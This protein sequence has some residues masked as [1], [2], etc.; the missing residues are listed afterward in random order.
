MYKDASIC[1]EETGSVEAVASLLIE[2]G[3]GIERS[4]G[5]LIE[6]RG[7]SIEE[8]K[9]MVLKGKRRSSEAHDEEDNV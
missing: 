7:L 9:E 5:Y 1:W 4:Q 2:R 8:A 3:F 6:Y